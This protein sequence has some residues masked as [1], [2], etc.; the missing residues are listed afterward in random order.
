LRTNDLNWNR[1]C[2]GI[3]RRG[4]T[5]S[6]LLRLVAAVVNVVVVVHVVNATVVE[7]AVVRNRL[8]WQV[9]VRAENFRGKIYI[10]ILAYFF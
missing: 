10:C 2:R 8:S 5:L 3:C 6:V 9:D 4:L 1:M 7:G